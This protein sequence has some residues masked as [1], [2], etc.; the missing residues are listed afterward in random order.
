MLSLAYSATSVASSSN[1]KSSHNSID[2][3][4]GVPICHS[5][6]WGIHLCLESAC[7]TDC[8]VNFPSSESIH[9]G[10]AHGSG[11]LVV[12]NLASVM[13][14]HLLAGLS[15]IRSNLSKIK[16][17]WGMRLVKANALSQNLDISHVVEAQIGKFWTKFCAFLSRPV[18]R[19]H[20]C[21]TGICKQDS[22]VV[23]N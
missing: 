13:W 6:P 23:K 3:H 8:Y 12:F 1:R 20:L 2:F 5:E 15:N 16:K 17:V 11:D 22:G 9:S 14:K 7:W 19:A 10:T 4:L 18:F 21:P